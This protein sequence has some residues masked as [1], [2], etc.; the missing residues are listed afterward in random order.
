MDGYSP[1]IFLIISEIMYR[2][3]VVQ[4]QKYIIILNTLWRKLSLTKTHTKEF[5]TASRG[6]ITV[7]RY[8]GITTSK[9]KYKWQDGRLPKNIMVH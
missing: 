7:E 5:Y 2:L 9:P 6:P 3:Y 1:V 8:S 4:T